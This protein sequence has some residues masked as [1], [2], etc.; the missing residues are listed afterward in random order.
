MVLENIPGRTFM[1]PQSINNLG[2]G[3]GFGASTF[4]GSS[5]L[6][7]SWNANNGTA[8]LVPLPAGQTLGR[9]YGINDTSQMAGSANGGSLERA[10]SYT[11]GSG[12]F[13][14]QSFA[15][16]GVLTT[17]YGINNNG[18][19][20]G[21]GLNPNNAAVIRGF[22]LDPGDTVATDI[23]SLESLGHNS[24]IAFAVS[25]NGLIVGSSSFNAGVD[26]RPFIWQQGVGMQEIP[27]LEGTS[28]GS[29]R[30]VNAWGQVVGNM[31]SATSVLFMYDGAQTWRL[32]DLL[33]DATGWDL[34][35]GTSNA[36]FGIADNGTI[37]G[38]GLLNGQITAF[39]M[40]VVP[41]PS[42]I[43]LW[44]LIPVAFLR[45]NRL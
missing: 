18:R 31:S 36:A 15:D 13:L 23:G 29:A 20:I 7:G 9:V 34:V 3:A 12:Q 28:Q 6:S 41:E 33:V 8:T 14:T 16:G 4:F 40:T 45:R 32:Q 21:Q 19:I 38:R 5:P 44:V 30:G 10:A 26:A 27:L 43:G 24:A 42:A 25:Q 11:P 2:I 35:G 17:A 22:Y 37:V 1:V 39:V